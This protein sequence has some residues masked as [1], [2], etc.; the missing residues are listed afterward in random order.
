[1]VVTQAEIRMLTAEELSPTRAARKP[2]QASV[3]SDAKRRKKKPVRRKTGRKT[4]G[5]RK[6]DGLRVK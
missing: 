6:P 2:A 1:M 4:A 3:A 5:Y